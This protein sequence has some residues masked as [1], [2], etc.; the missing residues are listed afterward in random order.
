MIPK[1]QNAYVWQWVTYC[2]QGL[3][4]VSVKLLQQ[5]HLTHKAC[6]CLFLRLARR[7]IF[8]LPKALK[9]AVGP[10]QTPIHRVPGALFLGL[11]QAGSETDL[12]PISSAGLRTSGAVSQLL[13]TPSW[14]AQTTLPLPFTVRPHDYTYSTSPWLYVQYVPMI[15]RTYHKRNLQCI[16]TYC[17]CNQ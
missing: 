16:D 5:C 14:C 1:L 17:Y 13:H 11:K 8:L 4:D 6:G 12:S 2:V 3:L 7:E 10:T 15:I 9:V